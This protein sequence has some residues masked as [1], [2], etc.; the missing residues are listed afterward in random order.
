MSVK[1][2]LFILG[3]PPALKGALLAHEFAVGVLFER[4]QS[5]F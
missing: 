4:K 5:S 3:V 1:S 2:V